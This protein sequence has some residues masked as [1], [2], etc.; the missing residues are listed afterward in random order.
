MYGLNILLLRLFTKNQ[1]ARPDNPD[2]L[3]PDSPTPPIG[4]SDQDQRFFIDMR[5]GA[6]PVDEAGPSN[7][8]EIVPPN[9]E[10]VIQ[11]DSD[12][13]W[14]PS[15]GEAMGFPLIKACIKDDI[16]NEQ[17]YTQQIG[18]IYWRG[19]P[20]AEGNGSPPGAQIGIP[21]GPPPCDPC[22]GEPYIGDNCFAPISHIH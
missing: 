12:P 17:E 14:D 22:K 19:E 21:I 18:R 11:S 4:E 1:M 8:T 20:E 5:E 13:R 7:F 15:L 9:E 10:P 2:S 3:F 16:N 6:V